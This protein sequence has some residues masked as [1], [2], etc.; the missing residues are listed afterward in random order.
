MP[1]PRGQRPPPG[2]EPPLQHGRLADDRLPGGQRRPDHRRHVHAAGPV[3]AGAGEGE[4]VLRRQPH[5]ASGTGLD[6]ARSRRRRRGGARAISAERRAVAPL[7]RRT[8]TAT[9]T[10]PATSRR[11]SPCRS[12][13]PSTPC[14]AVWAQTPSSRSRTS[15]RSCSPTRSC[16]A[17]G[18]RCTSRPTPAPWSRRRA[19]TRSCAPRWRGMAGGDLYDRVA[20][21][22]FRYATQRDWSVPHYEKMLEDNARLASLYLDAAVLA[23]GGRARRRRSRSRTPRPGGPLS[24]R[25]GGHDRLPSRHAVARRIHRPSGAARTRTSTTTASTPRGAPQL[26]EALRGPHRVRRL[27]RAGGAGAAARGARAPAPRAHERARSSCSASSGRHGRRDAAMAHYLTA[28]GEPGPGAPLLV[29]QATHGGGVAGRLRGHR[30]AP[31]AGGRAGARRLGRRAPARRRRPPARPP[32]RARRQRRASG[33]AAPRARGERAHGRGAPAPRGVHRRAPPGATRPAR[34]SP[35]GR[36]T[37]KS[38]ASPPRPTARRCSATSSGRTTSSSSGAAAMT[39]RGACTA[40]HWPR[41]GRCAPCSSS[42]RMTRPT[43]ERMAAARL[44]AGRGASRLRVPR[45][46][47]PGAHQRP[48]SSSAGRSLERESARMCSD[49]P[50][51][52]PR[53]RDDAHALS[54]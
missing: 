20:G 35:R 17:A 54:S 6:R 26:P 24:R 47:L 22:F 32:R 23:R 43:H 46:H 11:R 42:T 14:T 52:D 27:E 28:D 38:A 9:P 2:R 10:C 44:R 25:G 15:S 53:R 5:G 16:A 3:A 48:G 36:R 37:T 34:S 51:H 1:D 45:R 29:D 7:R 12:C 4:G 19:C 30:R 50:V 31:V 21:G 40:P 8:S 18:T 49:V 33:A 41:R 39:R 13:A